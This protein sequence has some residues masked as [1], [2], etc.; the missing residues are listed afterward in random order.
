MKYK[1]VVIQRSPA[2]NIYT[3]RLKNDLELMK[4]VERIGLSSDITIL[5]VTN[6]KE[7]EV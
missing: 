6:I 5:S 4:H 3:I 7:I 1:Y 2:K